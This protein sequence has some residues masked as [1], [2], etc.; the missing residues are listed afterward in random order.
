MDKDQIQE[1][2]TH[3]ETAMTDGS[4]WNDKV[5]AQA[6][7]RELGELKDMLEGLGKYDKG[8]AVVTIFAGAGGDDAEDFVSM[9][10]RMYM[11]YA[12]RKG[13]GL[14]FLHEHQN[15]RGGYRNVTFVV[16]GSKAYGNLKHENG[17]HRLVRVSPF[18]ANAKRHTSFVLV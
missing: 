2:I 17:V 3:I 7:I 5:R 12:E 1:R 14:S 11:K 18:N 13:Y 10:L 8:A 15:D 4:F 9:L 16:S 6:Q